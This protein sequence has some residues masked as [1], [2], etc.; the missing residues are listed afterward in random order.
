MNHHLAQNYKEQK[1]AI[2]LDR[3]AMRQSSCASHSFY[4]L[5]F[6]TH[7]GHFQHLHGCRLLPSRELGH[8]FLQVPIPEL[9]QIHK[10]SCCDL[11]ED[12]TLWH[13]PSP[14]QGLDHMLQ[15]LQVALA[16]GLRRTPHPLQC[17]LHAT[18]LQQCCM[19]QTSLSTG[20]SSGQCSG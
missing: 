9:D 5:T 20:R 1:N 16:S 18:T 17:M 2:S 4:S 12:F 14:G 11:I 7:L 6:Q 15:S 10:E 13:Q 3:K 19:E 8:A